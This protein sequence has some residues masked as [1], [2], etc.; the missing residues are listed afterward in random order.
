MGLNMLGP[1]EAVQAALKFLG[2]MVPDAKDPRLEE[3]ETSD[4]GLYW[5]ITLSYLSV[6]TPAE[7][8]AVIGGAPSRTFKRI[9]IGRN[10]GDFVFMRDRQLA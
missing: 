1:K 7:L 9:A 10:L 3:I 5:F 4:D 6:P 8:A 2:D